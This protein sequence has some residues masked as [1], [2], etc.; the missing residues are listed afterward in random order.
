MSMS[1]LFEENLKVEGWIGRSQRIYLGRRQ[2]K[3]FSQIGRA[4]LRDE[5]EQFYQSIAD[6]SCSWSD[7]D[8]KRPESVRE[9]MKNGYR[10]P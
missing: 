10:R 8:P 5:S 1:S 4:R 6:M 7:V 2:S 3:C 9:K